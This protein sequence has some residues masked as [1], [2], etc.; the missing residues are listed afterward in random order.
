MSKL[1]NETKKFMQ[2]DDQDLLET[3]TSKIKLIDKK[4]EKNKQLKASV[5]NSKLD[6]QLKIDQVM[7]NIIPEGL[8]NMFKNLGNLQDFVHTKVVCQVTKFLQS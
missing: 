8:R 7:Q 1:Y 5:Y 2:S 3:M 4:Y 6:K